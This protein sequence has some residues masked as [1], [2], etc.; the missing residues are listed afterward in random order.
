MPSTDVDMED[1]PNLAPNSDDDEDDD[2]P[3]VGEDA[4]ED[5]DCIFVAT[6]PCEA[7]FIQATSNVSQHLAEVFHKN[8][9]PKSFAESVPTHFHDFEDLFSKSSFD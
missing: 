6:I 8:S 1:I 5:G 2:K 7:E 3:Y 4:L 9:Q